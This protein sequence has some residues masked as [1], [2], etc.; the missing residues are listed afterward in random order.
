MS[1]D[2]R[3]VWYELMTTDP[4]A[5]KRFYTD[6]IGWTAQDWPGQMPYTVWQADGK[7]MGGL[8][9]MPDEMRSAGVPPHWMGYVCVSDVDATTARATKLG[10]SVRVPPTDIPEVGR[11]A[12]LGDPQGATIALLAPQ[13]EGTGGEQAKV[14]FVGWNELST[15]D[16]EAA[17]AFYSALFGW[18]HTS[19]LD[20]GEMGTYFMYGHADDPEDRSLGGI[21]ETARIMGVHPHWLYFVN[22]ADLEGAMERVK[23]SGGKVEHGP[24]DVPDGRIAVCQDPQGAPFAMFQLG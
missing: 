4:E 3:F 22:V 12:V 1:D 6:V 13:G 17:F 24:S 7:G 8:M 9:G 18:K 19:S 11:F 14:G 16:N 2:G 10:G 21:F 5:A 15:T 20:M 23:R